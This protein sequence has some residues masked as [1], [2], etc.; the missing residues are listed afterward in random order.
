MV[1]GELRKLQSGGSCTEKGLESLILNQVSVTHKIPKWC[2]LK[3][4]LKIKVLFTSDLAL[5]NV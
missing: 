5:E 4:Q 3:K 2:E 1:L